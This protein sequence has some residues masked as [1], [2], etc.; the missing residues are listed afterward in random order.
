MQSRIFHKSV[1]MDFCLF[2][3]HVVVF[4]VL[5]FLLILL[6]GVKEWLPA[7]LEHFL[8]I[9]AQMLKTIYGL[10]FSFKIHLWF[11]FS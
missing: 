3:L 6:S 8:L 5:W 9:F 1:G 7:C 4:C 11:Q 10:Q 2:V